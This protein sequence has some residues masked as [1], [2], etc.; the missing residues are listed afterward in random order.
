MT[1]PQQLI[2]KL[3]DKFEQGSVS[4]RELV[5]HLAFLAGAGAGVNAAAQS[6]VAPQG[7][8]LKGSAISHVSLSVSNLQR[9][10]EFYK[11]TLG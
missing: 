4:R 11:N 7:A 3:L 6:T 9:S 1:G 8:P 10:M 2:S 5:Q